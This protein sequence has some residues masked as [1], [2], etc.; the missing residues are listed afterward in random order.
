MGTLME[1]R[2]DAADA[3]LVRRVRA[4]NRAAFTQLVRKYENA[5]YATAMSMLGN[6]HDA[7]DVVQDSFLAAYIKLGQLRE[8]DRFG[9]WLRTIVRR[10]ALQWIRR[11]RTR[12]VQAYVMGDCALDI[13]R[14]SARRHTRKQRRADVWEAVGA[15]AEKYR[16]VVLLHY[17]EQW[18]YGRIAGFMRLPVSTVKGRLHTAREKLREYLSPIEKGAI[19]MKRAK[20]EKNVQESICKVAKEEIHETIPLG[21]TENIVL[22]CGVHADI[23]ICHTDGN[24]VILTG[25]RASVGFTEEDALASAQR[26]QIL[27]DQVDDYA[28]SG[29]HPGEVFAGSLADK[30]GN[31]VGSKVRTSDW[32]SQNLG[33]GGCTF[34]HNDHYPELLVDDDEIRSI[35][36]DACKDATRITVIREKMEDIIMP[37]GAYTESVQRVFMANWLSDRVH[38]PRGNVNLVVGVPAGKGITVITACMWSRLRARDLRSNL[39]A[40][41]AADVELGDIEGDVCLLRTSVREARG[42][43]GRFLQNCYELGGGNWGNY[44]GRRS[45]VSDSTIRDISGE[46]RLDVANV[47]LQASDL[48]GTVRI[49]NRFGSTRF[50]LN[51]HAEGSTYRIESDSGSVLVFLDESLLG[52]L[53]MTV[54]TLCGLITYEAL[55]DLGEFGQRNDPQL[56][57]FSTIPNPP[58]VRGLLTPDVLDVPLYIK[59]RDGDVTIE[60]TM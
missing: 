34:R 43:E 13:A 24:D 32:H 16:E 9:P 59:T 58:N 12:C 46:V 8:D 29:P 36:S 11:G 10:Q 5:A 17:V 28:K 54:S 14:A 35:I 42:I 6:E 31:P 15:L 47:N 25:T 41:C 49:R 19:P 51:K 50:H 18:S 33:A 27:H 30:D 56:M 53:N 26:I 23:E 2:S 3:E 48:T 38:G 55:K 52:E 60:K 1:E 37:R 40:I 22:F 21:D 20:V 4:G 44:R 7:L 45:P 39:T 57:S